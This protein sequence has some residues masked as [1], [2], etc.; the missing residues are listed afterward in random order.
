M[1]L[2]GALDDAGHW[3][4]GFHD[5]G[6]ANQAKKVAK[7]GAEFAEDPTLEEAADVFITM[8]GAVVIQGWS[9]DEVA[10]AIRVK[11]RTNRERSWEQLPDG[12]WQHT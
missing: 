2:I 7:E 12:T 4:A 8:A 5:N 1:S 6:V 9:W 11:M 3:V 10:A